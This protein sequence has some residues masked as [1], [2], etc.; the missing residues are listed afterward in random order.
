MSRFSPPLLRLFCW[1]LLVLPLGAQEEPP[2]ALKKVVLL[3]GKKSHGPEGNRIH[4]YLWSARLIKT[5]IEHSN[6]RDRVRVELHADGWPKDETSLEDAD[7]I[8][9]LSDG[10]DGDKFEEAPH[11]AS[12][13]HVA[14]IERQMKRG[15]GLVTFHFSTFAPDEYGEQILRWNGGYFDW[16]KDGKRDWFSAITIKE[17]QVELP[18]PGHSI[19]R[20]VKPFRMRE[21]FYYNIRFGSGD[22]ALTHLLSVPALQGRESDGN[23]VAWARQ[24]KDGGRGFGTTCGHFYDNWQNADFRR[25]I[26]NGIVWSARAEV[27]ADGVEARYF[28]RDEIMAATP[29]AENPVVR[30]QMPEFLEIPAAAVEELTAANG[31][32]GRGNA[33]D[34]PRSLGDATSARYSALK[35]INREN[36]KGLELAWTYHS[37]DGSG[38]IQCNP[39]IVDG[40]MFAPTAGARIVAVNAATGQELWGFKPEKKANRLE[41]APARRGLIY[42]SG[43]GETSPRIFFTAGNWIYALN[44]KKGE[45]I[46]SFGMGGRV[47]LPTGGTVAGAVWKTTLVVPGF[48]GDVFAFNVGTGKLQWRFRT[49][50]Q[51]AEFGAETWQRPGQGANC[52]GGMALDESRGIAYVSTG[53]PKPNFDGSGHP[54]ENLFANCLIA[55]NVATGERLWHFQEIRHD[56]WDLDVPAPPNLVSVMHEG[57]RVDAVAQVTKIGNTLLLDRVTG[58]PL[59]PFRLHRAPVSRLTGEITWPYQPDVQLPEPFARQVFSRADITDRT[60]EARAFIEQLLSRANMGWFEPF[61]ES[62]PT[63]FYGLHGGAEWTGSAFDPASGRLYV[64]ANE[65]PWI[66]TVFRD[67]DA[68]A[69]RPATAGEQL[70][71]QTCAAC[72]GA[73]LVGVGVA[74]PLRGLRHRMNDEQV[75]EIWKKG[76]NLMPPAPPMSEDQQKALLDFLFVRDRVQ[77]PTDL[78]APPR[79]SFGGY[80]KV[81]DHEEYPGSKPPWGTLNCLDLNSG[82]LLWKVPLGEY[83]ALTR[84]GVAK[85]GTENFGGAMVTAGGLVFCSGT[86]DNKIRA[87]DSATGAELW[88]APL[89]LHGTTAAATYEVDGR[90]FV[91]IPATGGGKLGGP[92]GDA[93]VAFALP[94]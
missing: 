42:W 44:P 51:G 50:P 83:Q 89:P 10:R 5:M 37:G 41:D 22:P 77:P 2:G 68:P 25:F 19:C 35:G 55:L 18:S 61:E 73:D 90:Q 29:D 11:L 1:F 47:E 38:N 58:K 30:A 21:E 48:N 45:P 36:V 52:W 56:I 12:A 9:I 69:A 3:A 24:R 84:A 4:D 20:G 80:R 7:T 59:F 40:V 79:Y 33:R 67:D 32:A 31:A 63:A 82:K 66:I 87:F 54:G 86:R 88:S 70:Y 53:S 39:V 94:K 46:E 23:V 74:P 93:Y 92:T 81:L 60:P 34:W 26:L 78:N 57:R 72:H 16:E 13:E 6:V 76:R 43:N 28:E 85:T 62:K 15:C 17:A 75:R 27:P 91:V 14:L 64:T 49:I 8:M 71:Q 65:L